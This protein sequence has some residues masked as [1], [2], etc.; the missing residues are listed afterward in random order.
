MYFIKYL[1][2]LQ[3]TFQTRQKTRVAAG[4]HPTDSAADTTTTAADTTTTEKPGDDWAADII[5][6]TTADAD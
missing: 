4:K 5:P 6:D 2:L 1:L 3:Y